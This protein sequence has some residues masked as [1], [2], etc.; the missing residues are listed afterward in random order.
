MKLKKILATT[1]VA[2]GLT[3]GSVAQ[4]GGIPVIDTASIAKYIEQIATMKEQIE[5]QVAQIVELKNQVQAVTGGRAMG[6]LL[7][8][9]AGSVIPDQWE[10]IYGNLNRTSKGRLNEKYDPQAGNQGLLVMLDNTE[11]VFGEIKNRVSKIEQLT[12]TINTTT[13]IKASQDLQ[14]RITAEQLAISNQQ[15]KLDQMQR[16]YELEKELQFK[17]H[18]KNHACDIKRQAHGSNYNCE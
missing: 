11:K 6:D 16:M 12:T 18:I 7:R 3:M 9:T 13:D 5:N 8:D 4:A 1:A 15:V 2:F 17:K 10:Q 14:A